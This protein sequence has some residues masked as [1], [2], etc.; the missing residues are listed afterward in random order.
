MTVAAPLATENDNASNRAATV[1][2]RGSQFF[3]NLLNTPHQRQEYH[4]T[5]QCDVRQYPQCVR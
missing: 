2:E 4:G 3:R 5:Q 1:M